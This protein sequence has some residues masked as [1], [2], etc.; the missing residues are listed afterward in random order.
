MEKQNT[1]E[2]WEL[3]EE[4]KVPVRWNYVSSETISFESIFVAFVFF[5]VLSQFLLTGELEGISQ[6]FRPLIILILTVQVVRRGSLYLPVR[7]VAV[8]MSV[9]QLILWF[10]LYPNGGL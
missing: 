6:P 9:Y 4:R 5:A 8:V 3:V 10:F 7:N 1:I 2:Q